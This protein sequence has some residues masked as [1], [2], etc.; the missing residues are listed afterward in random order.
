MW[1]ARPAIP[2]TI[3]TDIESA[4][5]WW[6]ERL[7][8]EGVEDNGSIARLRQAADLAESAKTRLERFA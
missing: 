5:G 7:A 8:R 4:T 3:F 2:A 6:K 1:I